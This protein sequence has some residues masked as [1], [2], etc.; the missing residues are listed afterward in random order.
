M[1]D[2]HGKGDKLGS[3]VKEFQNLGSV[4]NDLGSSAVRSFVV[5]PG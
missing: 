2:T 4:G 3:C 5:F 1:Q